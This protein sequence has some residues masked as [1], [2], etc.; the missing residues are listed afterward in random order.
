MSLRTLFIPISQIG[1]FLLHERDDDRSI[2]SVTSSQFVLELQVLL[3]A[4]PSITPI[5][6]VPTYTIMLNAITT[7]FTSEI[8][9]H[10]LTRKV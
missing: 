10:D 2:V 4:P 1:T 6:I 8:L 7:T 3:P 9:L 5:A